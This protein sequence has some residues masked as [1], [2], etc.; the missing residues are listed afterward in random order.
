MK[1]MKPSL[2]LLKERF[3]T[4]LLIVSTRISEGDQYGSK[5]ACTIYKCSWEGQNCPQED[6]IK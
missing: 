6:H 5:D 4:S 3:V 2:K 1:N